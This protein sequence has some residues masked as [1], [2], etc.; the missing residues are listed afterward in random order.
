[1][2]ILIAIN[3]VRM[4]IIMVFINAHIS[5]TNMYNTFREFD[6][7][8]NRLFEIE[9]FSS[10]EFLMIIS[11]ITNLNTKGDGNGNQKI[12]AICLLALFTNSYDYIA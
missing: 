12:C 4:L 3:I 9:L 6:N 2:L 8:S 5:Y 7:A 11:A 1:M 10:S